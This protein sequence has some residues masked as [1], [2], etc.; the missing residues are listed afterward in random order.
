MRNKK[1][2]L[3]IFNER[4]RESSLVA[5][6]PNAIKERRMQALYEGERLLEWYIGVHM[7]NNYGFGALFLKYFF[8]KKIVYNIAAIYHLINYWDFSYNL[9]LKKSF[10]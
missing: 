9:S 3:Q 1:L 5:K 2:F 6:F 7:L 4:E 10:K 8:K